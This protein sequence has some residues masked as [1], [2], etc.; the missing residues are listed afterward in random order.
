MM[1]FIW[2]TGMFAGAPFQYTNRNVL[3]LNCDE[4]LFCE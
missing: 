4:M 2:G 1:T 3:T